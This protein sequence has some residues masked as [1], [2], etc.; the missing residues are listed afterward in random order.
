MPM[1]RISPTHGIGYRLSIARRNP[2]ISRCVSVAK[3]CWH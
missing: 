2:A 1:I 3:C